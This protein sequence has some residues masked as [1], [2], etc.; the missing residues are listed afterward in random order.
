MP[1]LRRSSAAFI[2][3]QHAQVFARDFRRS[4]R[5]SRAGRIYVYVGVYFA[6]YIYLYDVYQQLPHQAPQKEF[7]LYGVLG[8]EKRH[9]G[10]CAAVARTFRHGGGCVVGVALALIFGR[11]LFMVLANM[12]ELAVR[13]PL[14]Y[15][16]RLFVGRNIVCGCIFWRRR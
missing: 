13:T 10:A 1:L 8:L 2:S 11:L 4:Q 9:V 5:R 3:C 14:S 15:R 12:I 6:L 7:G 16:Q